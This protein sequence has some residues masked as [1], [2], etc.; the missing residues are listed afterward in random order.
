MSG[1]VRVL[2]L[3]LA[4]VLLVCGAWTVVT[5]GYHA[6]GLGHYEPS[7]YFRMWPVV[8][9]FIGINGLL[10]LYHGS[11]L[12]PTAPVPPVEE[13]RRLVSATMLTHLGVIAVLALVRQTTEDYSRVV[14]VLSG[15]I[16]AIFGQPF[17]DLV[18][19]VIFKFSC[20][21]IPV[22]LAGNGE[23][24]RYVTSIVSKNPYLGFRIVRHLRKDQLRNAASVGRRLNVR[25]LVACSDLR[26]FQCQME[27]YADWF[28]H[29][30]YLP[31]ARMF[32]V[33]G[34]RA[35]TFD[36]L[37][38]LEM[39]SQRQMKAL[40]IQKWV[41]DKGIALLLFLG[42][43]PLFL[44][45]GIL[46]KLTSRGPVFYRQ[47]RLG[48]DGKPIRVWKFRS[49]YVDATERLR[50]ILSSDSSA[51]AEWERNFKLKKD[52]RVTPLGRFL[53]RT[54]IDELPQLFNVFAGEMAVIG[55]RPIVQEE[56][57]YYGESYKVF[58]SVLPGI[59]GLWQVSG[60]S[61][62]GYARRVELDTYYVLNW[63]PWMDF[64]I[65][66]RTIWAV[67]TMQGAR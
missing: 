31:T 32:P 9:V 23:M 46:I 54:S 43:L 53:R 38:G 25:V 36:G 11:L 40:R 39:V 4:D 51:A 27:D 66:L 67:A 10:R 64:W 8:F 49:M 6:L 50:Q 3:M 24:A 33:F 19:M 16:I 7:F 29:V 60:R 59:T 57:R 65:L 2:M 20:C 63:S 52:P 58:S 56:V 45:I 34:A 26:L 17:R 62:T 30:I 12:Y 22:L 5:L 35:V 21:R 18:R 41:L 37:G 47:D 28:T 15:L 55:P 61:D 1:H 42:L 48:K 14:I 44:V 13:L